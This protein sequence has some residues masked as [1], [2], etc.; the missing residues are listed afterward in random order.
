MVSFGQR[1]KGISELPC[2][3]SLLNMK[4]CAQMFS[5][6]DSCSAQVSSYKLSTIL[7][8]LFFGYYKKQII[9]TI[10]ISFH[11]QE[12]EKRKKNYIVFLSLLLD[13]VLWG[14]SVYMIKVEGWAK[15]MG[16]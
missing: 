4:Q 15:W 2:F 7:N 1:G 14:P 3:K 12:R 10:L 16:C 6:W 13:L 5:F 8:R 11:I 9:F